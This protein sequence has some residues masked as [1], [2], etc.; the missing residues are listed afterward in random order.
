MVIFKTLKVFN[1]KN[2]IKNTILDRT[3]I[4]GD[5]IFGQQSIKAQ[6]GIFSRPTTDFDIFTSKPKQSAFEMEK[7]LDRVVGFD[8][9]FT[10]PALHPGTWKV[11]S[12]GNDFKANTKDDIGII[13]YSGF[14]KPK[15]KTVNIKGVMFRR[16]SEEVAAKKRAIADPEFEFRKE[17]DSR[18]LSRVKLFKETNKFR[19]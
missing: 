15:P 19:F 16:L 11:I 1:S 12:K 13:D 2:A 7:K 10:K 6:T 9:F 4:K 18:D 14:P 8:N 3:S 5:I 17:K